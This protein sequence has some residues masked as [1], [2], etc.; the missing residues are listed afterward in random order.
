[1]KR[2]WQVNSNQAVSTWDTDQVFAA[3]VAA[4]EINSGYQKFAKFDDQF[5]CVSKP[6]KVLMHE[7]MVAQ[8]EFTED[9]W[10]QARAVRNHY[11]SL[12]FEQMAGELKDFLSTALRIATAIHV[13]S[14][15]WLDLA[16]I[17]ALPGCYKRDCERKAAEE[18][19]QLLQQRSSPVGQVGQRVQGRFEVVQCRWSDRW[20]RW[21][22][23]AQ[24][25]HNLFFFFHNHSLKPGD[26]IE[27]RGTV[28][29][30]RDGTVTQLN[31]VKVTV[32]HDQSTVD[33]VN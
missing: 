9:Q 26:Q 4:Q 19:R 31:R 32:L 22:V 11:Q 6:N 33:C 2:S 5:N 13:R 18:Q 17:A 1:M 25:D 15:N 29:C 12:L 7:M 28:K 20:C 21:T 10:A 30:H 8:C 16:V 23:N 3:A 27:V 14:N 24:Q